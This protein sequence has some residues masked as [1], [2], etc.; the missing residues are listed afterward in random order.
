MTGTPPP[1]PN[2]PA[3]APMSNP[4]AASPMNQSGECMGAFLSLDDVGDVERIHHA[5]R[6]ESEGL[7]IGVTFEAWRR[8]RCVAYGLPIRLDVRS[9]HIKPDAEAVGDAPGSAVRSVIEADLHRLFF[10]GL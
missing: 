1:M 4:V 7:G 6:E 10:D 2:V 8:T 5:V 9:L 3:R